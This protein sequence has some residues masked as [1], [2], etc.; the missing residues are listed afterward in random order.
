MRFILTADLH[1]STAEKDYSLAVLNEI[2]GVCARER[3][4]ALFLAGD[5]FDSRAD[6]EA[7]RGAFRA[8]IENLPPDCAVFFLPG[9]HEELRAGPGGAESLDRFDF[10]RARLLTEKPFS[11]GSPDP[12]TELLA[13]PFQRDYSGYR[14]WKAPP[15]RKPLRI[16]LAHGTVPGLAYTGPD[17]EE[18][19]GILD[20]DLFTWLKADLAALGHLHGGFSVRQGDTLIAYP[21]SA[22]VWREG[23]KGKR[24]V[25]LG[26]TEASSVTLREIPLE[27]AGEYRVVPVYAAP[28]GSLRV[29]RETAGFSPADWLSL[30]VSGLVEDERV[31]VQALERLQGDLKEKYRKVTVR[32]EGFSVLGGVSTHPLALRFIKKWEEGAASL[33]AEDPEAY[34]LARLRGL[35]VIK[36]ILESRR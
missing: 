5:V 17:E 16:V 1:I 35:G 2:V 30:E 29:P 15:K 22:R 6:V 7:L 20:A 23:E 36:E 3:C 34:N 13:I 32:T 14:A 4:E 11:F 8:G 33:G 21:G 26:V 10:G 9:N 28:D 27:R 12:Q 24:R 19:G 18:P 31:A 25:L